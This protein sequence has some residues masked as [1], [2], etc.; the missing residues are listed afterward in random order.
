MRE[1]LLAAVCGEGCG[2]EPAGGSATARGPPSGPSIP[3]LHLAPAAATPGN[4]QA[5]GA[6]ARGSANFG[7]EGGRAAAVRQRVATLG[8]DGFKEELRFEVSAPAYRDAS[9]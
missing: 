9:L 3:R 1:G 5:R 2:S 4:P 6:G 7:A 8:S